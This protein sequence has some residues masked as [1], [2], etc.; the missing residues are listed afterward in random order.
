MLFQGAKTP[1]DGNPD[2]LEAQ[3][4]LSAR[5]VA[6]EVFPVDGQHL[7]R[8]QVVEYICRRLVDGED[9]AGRSIDLVDL[10]REPGMPKLSVVMGWRR[11]NR[12]WDEAILEAEKVA[13]QILV[14]EARGI[15]RQAEGAAQAGG[16]KLAVEALQW[17][18]AK[19]DKRFADRQIVEEEKALAGLS[20]KEVISQLVAALKADPEAMKALAPQLQGVIDAEV[21]AVIPDA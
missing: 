7:T 12:I 1:L 5:I 19:L 11:Q 21:L 14:H 6:G 13:A 15:A 2:S 10:C 16:S 18:A 3:Q 8:P 4:T 17:E 9:A 20:D